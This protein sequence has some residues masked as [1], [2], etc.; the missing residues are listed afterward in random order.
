VKVFARAASQA[1]ARDVALKA[2]DEVKSRL[3]GAL[4]GEGDETFAEIVGRS[5]RSRRPIG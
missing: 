3:G 2:S 5:M 1:L 4:Y